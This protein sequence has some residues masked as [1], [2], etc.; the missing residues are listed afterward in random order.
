LDPP[1]WIS[2]HWNNAFREDLFRQIPLVSCQPTTFVSSFLIQKSNF[3]IISSLAHSDRRQVVVLVFRSELPLANRSVD[4]E[5]WMAGSEGKFAK[6]MWENGSGMAALLGKPWAGLIFNVSFALWKMLFSVHA[7]SIHSG[8]HPGQHFPH[9]FCDVWRSAITA[10]EW[11][12]N[13]Q[14]NIAAPIIRAHNGTRAWTR[15]ASRLISSWSAI[16]GWIFDNAS[17]K[18]QQQQWKQTWN[19]KQKQKRSGDNFGLTFCGIAHFTDPLIFAD[20]FFFSYWW[21]HW[22]ID[23]SNLWFSNLWFIDL[24]I[25]KSTT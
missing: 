16:D 2:T 19:N 6:L 18:Q 21:I 25:Q 10:G 24:I 22:L 8:D 5:R 15:T 11:H 14:C 9:L 12:T 20:P 13:G 4:I 1:N 23:L 3:N 7:M 17:R